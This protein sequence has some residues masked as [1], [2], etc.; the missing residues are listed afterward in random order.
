[1]F[2]ASKNAPVLSVWIRDETTTPCS[3]QWQCSSLQR[4]EISWSLDFLKN[5]QN[6]RSQIKPTVTPIKTLMPI[7]LRIVLRSTC[8]PSIIGSISSLVE[9]NTAT[10]VPIVIT[11]PAKRFAAMALN[12]HCG[13]APRRPPI[14]GPTFCPRLSSFLELILCSIN[15]NSKNVTKR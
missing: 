3:S 11:R 13:S 4:C 14:S 8:S 1:M 9:R 6:T 15:S 2:A 5:L 10:T 12:P 7:I